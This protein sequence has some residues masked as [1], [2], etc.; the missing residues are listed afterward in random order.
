MRSKGHEAF[1]CT[2][3]SS[4]LIPRFSP[5]QVSYSAPCSRIASAYVGR[6]SPFLQ[7][8]QALRVNRGIALLFSRI[9]GTRWVWVV[10]PMPRR[11]LPPGKTPY[12][13]YRRLGILF[14]FLC[15]QHVSYINISVIRS[16]QLY[17][18]I[19]PMW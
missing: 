9:F 11:P 13:L 19:R 10:S 18:T 4:L 3:F 2:I 8:M 15:A 14:R 7:A 6:F 1:N 12:P 16:L 17:I 5:T